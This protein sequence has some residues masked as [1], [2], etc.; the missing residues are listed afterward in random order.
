M[1][2]PTLAD[3]VDDIEKTIGDINQ[4]LEALQNSL[5]D[6]PDL[7]TCPPYCAHGVEPVYVDPRPLEEQVSDI[8][9]CIGDLKSV[10]MGLKGALAGRVQ[11]TCPP[12]CPHE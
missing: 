6:G 7:P 8:G 2:E 4:V 11:P 5:P 1:E 3:R 10:F 9:K 12:Y